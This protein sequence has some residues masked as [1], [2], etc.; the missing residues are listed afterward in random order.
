M[1]S[2]APPTITWLQSSWV[3]GGTP[4]H[5]PKGLPP[6]VSTA[7]LGVVGTWVWRPGTRKFGG[8]ALSNF[9]CW[10]PP[11]RVVTLMN[12]TYVYADPGAVT[13]D[14]TSLPAP[15]SPP[16]AGMTGTWQQAHEAYW[17]F[18]PGTGTAITPPA[19]TDYTWLWWVLGI[20]AVGG[21]AYLIFE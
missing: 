1:I 21:V 16:V 4:K 14:W 5:A 9:W 18:V 19:A 20:G 8:V 12:G 11:A 13:G 2:N 6:G 3:V 17:V 15:T 10:Y 7:A